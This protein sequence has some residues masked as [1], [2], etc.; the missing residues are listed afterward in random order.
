M[1]TERVDNETTGDQTIMSDP[2]HNLKA[3]IESAAGRRVKGYG[4]PG[5]I[6]L[7]WEPLT[8]A[9]CDA[10]ILLDDDTECWFG[11]SSLRPFDASRPLPV[12]DEAMR[13][14]RIERTESLTQI[15]ANLIRD[16][17]KPW[18][19]MEFGKGHLGMAINKAL[20]SVAAEG[21]L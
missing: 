4:C 15:R 19:G 7:R 5:G 11:L 1:D 3:Y 10:L 16:W 17:N 14:S 8:A 21:S 2:L 6:I 9:L 13:L 12:R 18:P 20:E